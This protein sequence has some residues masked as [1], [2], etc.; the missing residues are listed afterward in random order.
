MSVVVCLTCYDVACTWYFV[1]VFFTDAAH[2]SIYT[3]LIVG[4][5]RCV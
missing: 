4:G 1:G 5:V 2:V 3:E